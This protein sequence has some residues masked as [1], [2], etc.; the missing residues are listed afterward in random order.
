MKSPTYI[1]AHNS[2]P[3]KIQ[4]TNL[5]NTEEATFVKEDCMNN[6]VCISCIING[7]KKISSY[8]HHVRMIISERFVLWRP[9]GRLKV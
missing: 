9:D 3:P 8:Y 4:N 2:E 5:P 7:C 1:T 6:T